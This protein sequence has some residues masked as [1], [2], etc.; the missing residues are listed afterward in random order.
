MADGMLIHLT[1][2]KVGDDTYVVQPKKPEG[3][4]ELGSCNTYLGVYSFGKDEKG[5]YIAW[6][7]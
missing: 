2:L 7:A 5:R 4:Q 6:K 1:C 3:I